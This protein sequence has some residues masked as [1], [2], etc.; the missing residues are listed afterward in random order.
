MSTRLGRFQQIVRGAIARRGVAIMGVCNVTPDSF[1]DGG[2]FLGIERARERILELLEEGADIIDIGGESTRPGAAVVP[3]KV[4]LERVLEAVTFAV[5]RAHARAC[6]SIDTTDPEVAEA[7]LAAGAHAVN[8]VSLL[9]NEGLADVSAAHRAALIL[10]HARAPQSDMQGFGGWPVSA[11]ADP[12]TDVLAEWEAA[13]RRAVARGLPREALVMDPGLGFSKA[14]RTS[15]ELLRRM[16]ELVDG[17]GAP[18][19]VGASRKSHL[20][21]VDRGAP[22]E[23]RLGASIAAALHAARSG[24]AV[25]RVHDVRATRQAVDLDTVLTTPVGHATGMVGHEPALSALVH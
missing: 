19:L 5:A 1:S 2:R 6:V 22:P 11:Y 10:S 13:A 15:L 7:C 4:Q 24:A 20:T 8:D 9:A 14:A 21:L 3:A 17:A 12:V 18:V 23:A 25:V 16:R